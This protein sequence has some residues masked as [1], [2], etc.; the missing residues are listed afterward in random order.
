M[1]RIL[2][3]TQCSPCNLVVAI[4]YLRRY[5]NA[6]GTPL[7]LTSHN[8][9]R[10]LL[11]AA[12]LASKFLDEPHCTNRQVCRRAACPCCDVACLGRAR[13]AARAPL[14]CAP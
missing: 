4:I 13:C 11:T 1:Q 8:I 3:H 2:K 6:A 10:L 12:M 9:Q 5:A 7:R 14:A